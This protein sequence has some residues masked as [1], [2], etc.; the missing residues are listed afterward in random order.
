MHRKTISNSTPAFIIGEQ[1]ALYPVDN[2][3]PEPLKSRVP[4]KK[5]VPSDTSLTPNRI[6]QT[7]I[8]AKNIAAISRNSALLD[9][10]LVAAEKYSPKVLG[11]IDA[12]IDKRWE[13]ARFAFLVAEL[14]S[15]TIA[16]AVDFSQ[17]H[18]RQYK[19]D[20][21]RFVR[22]LEGPQNR[23]PRDRLI[24]ELRKLA[25]AFDIILPTKV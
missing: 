13:T 17:E 14:G 20:W 15:H 19:E 5:E 10:E 7:Y 9:N 18:S 4:L 16:E 25:K 2:V 3:L 12:N 22:D 11:K 21:H 1:L 24:T 23:K 6:I 8:A